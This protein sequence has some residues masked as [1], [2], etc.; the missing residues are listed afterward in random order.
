MV[1]VALDSGAVTAKRSP[2]RLTG[3]NVECLV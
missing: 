1:A 2:E 3:L